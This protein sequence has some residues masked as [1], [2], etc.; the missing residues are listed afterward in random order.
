MVTLCFSAGELNSCAEQSGSDAES[1]LPPS[2][3]GE[4][5]AASV[6]VNLPSSYQQTL[7]KGL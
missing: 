5:A 2:L 3:T 7:E 6:K 1:S 4:V